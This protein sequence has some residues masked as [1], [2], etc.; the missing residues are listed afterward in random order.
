MIIPPLFENS[1]L[2]LRKY[3]SKPKNSSKKMSKPKNYSY[4]WLIP[5]FIAA[6][7]VKPKHGCKPFIILYFFL[8][9]MS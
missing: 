5:N 6:K 8:H 9:S 2:V 1:F 3:L 4:T 7:N